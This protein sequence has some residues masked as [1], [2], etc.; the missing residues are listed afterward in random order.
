M[1]DI[2]EKMRMAI[3]FKEKTEKVVI[4]SAKY[5]V[6]MT[7][8]I[9][10]VK[11]TAYVGDDMERY[12]YTMDWHK[13]TR[14][15]VNVRR[16]SHGLFDDFKCQYNKMKIAKM[17]PEM[18]YRLLQKANKRRKKESEMWKVKALR[19]KKELLAEREL[20]RKDYIDSVWH[21]KDELPCGDDYVLVTDGTGFMTESRIWKMQHHHRWAYLKDLLPHIEPPILPRGGRFYEDGCT[22]DRNI[23]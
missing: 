13:Q 23:W 14:Q 6:A 9:C 12:E 11:V 21:S 22:K 1:N 19:Y 8:G 5:N 17:P 16:K 4:E 10:D 7:V 20:H 3:Q 15:F 18:M 2:Q